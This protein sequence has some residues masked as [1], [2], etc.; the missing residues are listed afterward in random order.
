MRSLQ[1][2]VRRKGEGSKPRF[3]DQVIFF[4][5]E[6]R[7]DGQSIDMYVGSIVKPYHA[8]KNI[9]RSNTIPFLHQETHLQFYT[10]WL[11]LRIDWGSI[12]WLS[13]NKASIFSWIASLP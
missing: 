6:L 11:V 13:Y 2:I 3:G 9:G 1:K 10:Q 8:D 4:F 7:A 5:K 12:E